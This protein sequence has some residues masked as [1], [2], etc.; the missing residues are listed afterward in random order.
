MT[1]EH[2]I[3]RSQGGYPADILLAIKARFFQFPEPD[4]LRLARQIDEAN[5]V[6]ACSFC[7][8][9]TSR[10]RSSRNMEQLL[11]EA[12]GS[13]DEVLAAISGELQAIL[14]RKRAEVQWKLQSVRR[15]FDEVIVPGLR[16]RP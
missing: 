16:S 10:D 2:L 8:S 9:M 5:T 14:E 11:T 4:Q 13:P 1:V 12:E 15:A 7:N 3:G 6:T